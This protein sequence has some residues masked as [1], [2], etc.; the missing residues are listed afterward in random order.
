M[1]KILFLIALYVFNLLMIQCSPP[2]SIPMKIVNKAGFEIDLYWNNHFARKY[3]SSSSSD[4]VLQPTS[5]IKSP[6][7]TVVNSFVG[8]Q[9]VIR[10]SHSSSELS[11]PISDVIITKSK[12][13]Y[14]V[15]TITYDSAQHKLIATRSVPTTSQQQ[16]GSEL[17]IMFVLIVLGIVLSCYVLMKMDNKFKKY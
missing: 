11:N 15:F 16:K 5:P 2:G 7:E 17:G 4:M 13:E 8:H 6:G 10:S 1:A 12:V 3:K 9:F 14:E